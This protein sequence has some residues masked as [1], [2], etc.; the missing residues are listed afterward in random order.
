MPFRA[1]ALHFRTSARSESDVIHTFRALRLRSRRS[2]E[3]RRGLDQG[4]RPERD[5][6]VTGLASGTA[7]LPNS[8]RQRVGNRSCPSVQLTVDAGCPR[9]CFT[10]ARVPA[11]PLRYEIRQR[12]QR[13]R[14]GVR[15]V[16]TA[17][18]EGGLVQRDRKKAQEKA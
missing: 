18:L 1:L 7:K 14:G 16:G 10:D 8:P 9:K 3:R 13:D 5:L 2:S 17:R 12:M 11:L 6:Q 4:R 15:G